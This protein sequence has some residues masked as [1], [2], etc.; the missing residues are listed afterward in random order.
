[1]N[2][3]EAGQG[4]SSIGRLPSSTLSNRAMAVGAARTYNPR[5]SRIASRSGVW[6]RLSWRV[7]FSFI[8]APR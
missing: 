5:H 1:V 6:L 4:G 2:R 7:A 8:G 3:R